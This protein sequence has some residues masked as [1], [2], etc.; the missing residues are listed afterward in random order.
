MTTLPGEGPK[1]IRVQGQDLKCQICGHAQFWERKVQ[2]NTR[3]S[4]MF[5]LDWTDPQAVCR[6]CERCGFILWFMPG[7]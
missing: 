7:S 5:G 2:M 6:I 1:E 3:T 4:Q